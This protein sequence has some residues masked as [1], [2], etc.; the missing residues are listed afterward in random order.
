MR[1][2]FTFIFNVHGWRW[3]TFQLATFQHFNKFSYFLNIYTGSYL[4]Q[5]TSRNRVTTQNQIHPNKIFKVMLID[6]AR[7]WS[8]SQISW[9]AAYLSHML[10][11]LPSGIVI[12]PLDECFWWGNTSKNFGRNKLSWKLSFKTKWYNGYGC[13][14]NSQIC[15]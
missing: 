7:S 1:W 15:D 11:C 4:G 14:N 3:T 5:I 8:T 9:V 10:A 13:S 12:T 6:L 2:W